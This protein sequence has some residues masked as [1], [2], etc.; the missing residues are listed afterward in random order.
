V[1]EYPPFTYLENEETMENRIKR[2]ADWGK[3]TKK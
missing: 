2:L 3:A 1:I